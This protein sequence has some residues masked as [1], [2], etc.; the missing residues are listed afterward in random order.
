[1]TEANTEQGK[2]SAQQASK[3]APKKG[4]PKKP[5]STEKVKKK[6]P[7]FYVAPGRSVTALT[8]ILSDGDEV[9]PEFLP[10]GEKT[11]SGLVRREL[12]IKS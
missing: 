6:K 1:M 9:R 4:A 3:A 8:G 12:V 7:P 2:E 10:G 5:E 11:L